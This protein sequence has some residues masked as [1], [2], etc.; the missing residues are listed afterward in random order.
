MENEGSG[1]FVI[2]LMGIFLM[3]LMVSFIVLMLLYHRQKQ[4][5]NQE[6]LKAIQTEYEKTM[7]NVEKEIRE[8]TLSFVGRELHDNI[9]QL[10][11]LAK[12]NL[13]SAKPEKVANGKFMINDI[14]REVRGL[15]KILNLEWL[16]GY[17]LETFI[18]KELD[19][20]THAEFC[21][22]SFESRVPELMLNKDEKL[23]LIRIIQEC[24]NNAI[25][26]A[27]PNHI[28][29]TIHE[30]DQHT[31]IH[32]RDDGVGFDIQVRGDGSGLIN[33][34]KR[35]ETIGGTLRIT[36]SVGN[37]TSIELFLPKFGI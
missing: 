32:L 36:S 13:S 17:S 28:S 29:I 23:I 6:K 30:Q 7:L 14:I 20:L 25:K 5:K 24:I 22:T 15:S 1:L 16:E 11:S 33:L 27:R 21:T 19:K 35:M 3:L 26:H 4:I 37:G 31:C 34:K 8:E 10:L 18:Q 12:M 2:I 9:G